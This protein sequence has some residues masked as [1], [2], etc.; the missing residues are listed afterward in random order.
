MNESACAAAA[1]DL[2]PSCF[3]SGSKTY[4]EIRTWLLQLAC[5]DLY[6]M[7]KKNMRSVMRLIKKANFEKH[8]G[9][10]TLGQGLS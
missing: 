10:I 6:R 8:F 3:S 5:G 7:A 2:C 4:D 1:N 9:K